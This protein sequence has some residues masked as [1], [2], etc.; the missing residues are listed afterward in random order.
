V[1]LTH[2]EDRQVRTLIEML[3]L[4]TCPCASRASMV[5]FQAPAVFRRALARR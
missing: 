4:S 5:S 3:F 2:G 1:L